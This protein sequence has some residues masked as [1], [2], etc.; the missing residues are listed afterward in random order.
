[1]RVRNKGDLDIRY[2]HDEYTE[3][4]GNITT[5]IICGKNISNGKHK[6]RKHK[7]PIYRVTAENSFG[8]RSIRY[9]C[10]TC[11]LKF[12]QG[13]IR[14]YQKQLKDIPQHVS[15]LKGLVKENQKQLKGYSKKG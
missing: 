14:K 15:W 3:W 6:G 5:C 1:M 8:Q 4:H 12:L 10:R 11:A 7:G 13:Q 9:V 2:I